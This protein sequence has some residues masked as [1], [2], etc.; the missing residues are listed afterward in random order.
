VSGRV[1][2]LPVGAL[3]AILALTSCG[4]SASERVTTVSSSPPTT[5]IPEQTAPRTGPYLQF[6]SSSD[7]WFANPDSSTGEILATTEGG[8]T[9]WTSYRGSYSPTNNTGF[10]QSLDFVNSSD[11]WALLGGLGLIATTN[12]GKTWSRPIEP[13]EGPIMSVMFSGPEEGWAITT[14]GALL[15]SSD[16]G[17]RW[18]V[19]RTPV[20]AIAVCAASGRLW[21]ASAK[22]DDLYVSDAGG[23]WMLSFMGSEAPDIHNSV[24]PSPK[25]QGLWL[26]C[27]AKT[28]FAL[29]DYGSAA[30]S[31]PYVLERTLDGGSSW[32]AVLGAGVVPEPPS[33]WV[34]TNGT[35]V[36]FGV[37][38]PSNAW[39]LTYCGPC[40]EG[41][42]GIVTTTNGS[43]FSSNVFPYVRGT[44]SEAIDA[45]F[46]DQANGWA[47]LSEQPSSELGRT[48]ATTTVVLAT[49]DGGASWEVVDRKLNR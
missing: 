17:K 26:A 44:Y 5:F 29:Y 48:S 33:P 7:G 18:R 9:W 10:V 42:P 23:P 3:A 32:A 47:V 40:A 34:A 4:T 36:D 43:T 25:P 2:L 35:L 19:V 15:D 31:T 11:G 46:S 37:T 13:T 28:A 45:A 6:A 1:G 14:L 20:R 16:A 22:G 49:H 30:G 38:G 41:V 27:N 8:R 12:G 39:L 21:F 24:G